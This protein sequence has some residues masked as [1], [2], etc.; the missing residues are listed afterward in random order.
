MLLVLS[1]NS[2]AISLR[3]EEASGFRK[4][5]RRS[6]MAVLP[7]MRAESMGLRGE[8]SVIRGQ[9]SAVGGEKSWAPVEGGA[10]DRERPKRQDRRDALDRAIKLIMQS[11]N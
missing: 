3:Y 4:N 10:G 5:L 9:R 1:L 8:S 7:V 11:I 6:L 2:D